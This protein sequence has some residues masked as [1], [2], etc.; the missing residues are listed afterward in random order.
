MDLLKLVTLSAKR[1]E[2]LLRLSE[3]KRTLKDFRELFGDISQTLIPELKKLEFYGLIEKQNNFFSLTEIGTVVV[4]SMSNFLDTVSALEEYNEFFKGHRITVFPKE[5]ILRIGE[6]RGG[7]VLKSTRVN[8]LLTY[9]E[10][11]KLLGRSTRIFGIS[12]VFY[13]DFVNTFRGLAKKGKKIE[14]ILT[15]EVMNLVSSQYKEAFDD[16]TKRRSVNVWVYPGDILFTLTASDAFISLGLFNKD[17]TY[18]VTR[19]LICQTGAALKWGCD[20]FNYFKE[21][22]K[23]IEKS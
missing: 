8:L 3:E 16:F 4:Q 2:M 11:R 17:G 23:V 6:L 10:Y 22:S 9:F 5:F 7:K 21:R 18:D 12:P 20:L 19:D 1:R 14:L 13:P 15:E